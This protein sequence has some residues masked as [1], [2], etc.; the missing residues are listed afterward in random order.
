[1]KVFDDCPSCGRPMNITL[2][3]RLLMER[4]YKQKQIR[5]EL[6]ANGFLLEHKNPL[7]SI[8]SMMQRVK[9]KKSRKRKNISSLR[10]M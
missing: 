5:A 9:E 10:K 6:F 7:A 1:M 2:F 4:G 3:V 8:M